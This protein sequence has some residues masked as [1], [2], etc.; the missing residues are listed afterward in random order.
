VRWAA[1][2]AR[3]TRLVSASGT[4]TTGLTFPRWV[5]EWARPTAVDLAQRDLMCRCVWLQ[6]DGNHS[7][8]QSPPSSR[9][10][11]RQ[12][13]LSDSAPETQARCFKT[14]TRTT[15]KTKVGCGPSTQHSSPGD[16]PRLYD[17]AGSGIQR[18]LIL[19][20]PP[21]LPLPLSGKSGPKDQ[22]A[23]HYYYTSPSHWCTTHEVSKL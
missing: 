16:R 9:H 23:L 7:R 3:S 12:W 6:R 18:L 8:R 22:V 14:E 1:P 11:T 20:L 2:L 4:R 19:L 17:T 5:S 15:S 13:C 21:L 10:I